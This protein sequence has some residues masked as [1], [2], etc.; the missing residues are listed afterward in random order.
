M[1]RFVLCCPSERRFMYS[2]IFIYHCVHSSTTAV[3]CSTKFSIDKNR[4]KF[5][6]VVLAILVVLQIYPWIYPDTAMYTHYSC[7]VSYFPFIGLGSFTS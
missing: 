3:Q 5:S 2:S 6:M 4:T 7:W 1:N